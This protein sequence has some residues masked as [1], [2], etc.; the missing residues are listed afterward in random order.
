MFVSFHFCLWP[1][2]AVPRHKGWAHP[3]G[4]MGKQTPSTLRGQNTNLVVGVRRRRR[5]RRVCLPPLA[6]FTGIHG[7]IKWFG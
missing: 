6:F 7:I 1:R 3:E 4:G 2:Q 5:R